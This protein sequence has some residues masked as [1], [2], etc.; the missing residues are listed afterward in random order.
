M[1]YFTLIEKMKGGDG[2]LYTCQKDNDLKYLRN[3]EEPLT[4][5]F[6]KN[7]LIGTM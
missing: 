2:L 4:W 7:V 5:I 3:L 1:T 6:L